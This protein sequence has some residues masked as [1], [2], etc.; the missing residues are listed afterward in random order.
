MH[1]LGHT[2]KLILE[3]QYVINI[4]QA[5][6]NSKNGL[7]SLPLSKSWP[8]IL[9]KDHGL[10]AIVPQIQELYLNS[11]TILRPIRLQ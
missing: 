10:Q 4:A 1:F 2:T 11:Y 3:D 6:T 5:T 8:Y 7:P 9:K